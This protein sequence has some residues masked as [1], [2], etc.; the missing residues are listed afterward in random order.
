ML[1]ALHVPQVR[2]SV[3]RFDVILLTLIRSPPKYVGLLA[4]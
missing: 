3:R 1:H 2:Y 4:V